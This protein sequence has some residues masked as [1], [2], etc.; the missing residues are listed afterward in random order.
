LHGYVFAWD[1]ALEFLKRNKLLGTEK[2]ATFSCNGRV[3]G[4]ANRDDVWDRA[5]EFL[6]RHKLL[7][8]ENL[9]TFSCGGFWPVPT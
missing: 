7:G 2:L 9:A 6:R 1:R 5:L 3:L 8:T 4:C